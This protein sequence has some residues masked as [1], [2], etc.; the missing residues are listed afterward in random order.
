MAY[1]K[2]DY[3]DDRVFGRYHSGPIVVLPTNKDDQEYAHFYDI[4]E[5]T[6]TDLKTAIK[7]YLNRTGEYKIITHFFSNQKDVEKSLAYTIVNYQH[8][9][10][11]GTSNATGEQR[12]VKL[13]DGGENTSY[14][15]R[16][17]RSIFYFHSTSEG[18]QI[19]L[20]VINTSTA[21]ID[22]RVFIEIHF[23][24]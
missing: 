9:G 14:W 15:Y 22:C 11:L 24:S 6:D 13:T 2:V 17:E 20:D 3:S 16:S 23:L 21:P 8:A 12:F 1:I 10:V 4:Y 18:L 19:E 5:Q 7:P